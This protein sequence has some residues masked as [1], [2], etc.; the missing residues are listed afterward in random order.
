LTA[1]LKPVTPQAW[2]SPTRQFHSARLLWQESKRKEEPSTSPP[3]EQTAEPFGAKNTE[4]A[5]SAEPKTKAGEQS[6]S[7]SSESSEPKENKDG[8][9][10]D[11]EKKEDTP[12]PPHGDKTP[13]QVFTDTLKTEFQ[14]S[15]E[16]NESTKA[17]QSGYQDFT[18]NP[19]LQKAK[20]AYDAASSTAASTTSAALKTTGRAIGHSAA[21]AW[22]TPVAKVV[23]KGTTVVGSG[24]E[25]ATRP[26]RETEAY[27]NVKDVI[28]DGSSS[29][30][31]GWV[32]KEERKKIRARREAEAAMKG[33]TPSHP[34]V[35]DPK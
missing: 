34:L 35:E 27:K 22:D 26:V 9:K 3:Q 15:K 2:S 31:G 14:A 19:A 29:R 8:E 30:Y 6:E 12:P 1:T 28:D 23:R 13:W 24:L 4:S 25:K 16:W 20:G 33:G 32:E 10:K 18:Q 11:G 21:W 7:S 5:E 17:L